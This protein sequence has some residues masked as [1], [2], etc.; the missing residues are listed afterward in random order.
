MTRD[1]K[2]YTP[3]TITA[4]ASGVIALIALAVSLWDHY[5]TREYYKI[6]VYP[7]LRSITF[8]ANKQD[9]RGGIKIAN[10]G[11]GPAV[12]DSITYFIDGKQVDD[13]NPQMW[14]ELFIKQG[15]SGS[16]NLER[17]GQGTIIRPGDEKILF[18]TYAGPGTNWTANMGDVNRFLRHL[19]FYI[20]YHSL[21]NEKFQF[22]F[23]KRLYH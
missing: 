19:D 14:A 6:S 4:I 9:P 15:L 7:N 2:G 22:A 12:V 21:Y 18:Y 1:G 8:T 3:D 23:D 10:G 17:I 11:L 5:D 16:W 13:G 20:V